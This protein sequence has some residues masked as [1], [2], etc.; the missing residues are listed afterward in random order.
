MGRKQGVLRIK[1]WAV[2]RGHMPIQTN[3]KNE[4]VIA[5]ENKPQAANYPSVRDFFLTMIYTW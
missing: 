1:G 3:E 2:R 4:R 5:R